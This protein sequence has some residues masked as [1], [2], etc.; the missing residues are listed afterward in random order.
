MNDHDLNNIRYIMSLDEHQFDE[1]MSKVG[2]DDINY[3]IEIIKARRVELMMEEALLNDE[4]E[5][6]S[7]AQKVLTKFTLKG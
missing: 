2:D 7:E 6:L 4:V 1:W 3:A 5:D